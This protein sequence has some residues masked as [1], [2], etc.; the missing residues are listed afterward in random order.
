[1]VGNTLLSFLYDELT[2]SFSH[3]NTIHTFE[4]ST[5]LFDFYHIQSHLTFNLT[6][7]HSAVISVSTFT[8]RINWHNA[9]LF[10][11]LERWAFSNLSYFSLLR[12]I[13]TNA[14][15]FLSHSGGPL[16]VTITSEDKPLVTGRTAELVCTV[17]GSNPPPLISWYL[18]GKEVAPGK[19]QV[20]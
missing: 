8:P 17:V 7:R 10:F 4:Q 13:L 6:K 16:L 12:P 20:S 19:S 18:Q 3:I 2:L 9:S 15:L 11:S 1:M 14:L 5:K